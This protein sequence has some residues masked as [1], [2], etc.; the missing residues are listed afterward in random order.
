MAAPT[1]AAGLRQL[2]RAYMPFSAMA[3][4]DLDFVIESVEIGYFAPDEVVLAP[5]GKVPTHCL[6]VKDG[7]VLAEAAD[8]HTY[9]L[10]DGLGDGFAVGALL[11]ERPVTLAYR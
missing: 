9:A 6:I 11:A 1:I 3:A 4:E 8:M 2:L 10:E 5:T 7:C